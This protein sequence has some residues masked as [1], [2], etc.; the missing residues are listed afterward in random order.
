MTCLIEALPDNSVLRTVKIYDSDPIMPEVVLEKSWPM[1]INPLSES[2]ERIQN[3]K[4]SNVAHKV[5]VD[6]LT[7]ADNTELKLISTG[8]EF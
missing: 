5:I 3:S 2:D 7:F 1:S 8:Q 4:G 6:S